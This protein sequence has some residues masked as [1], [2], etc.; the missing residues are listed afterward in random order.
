M[1]AGE[2]ALGTVGSAL[3][4][5]QMRLFAAPLLYLVLQ[6]LLSVPGLTPAQP[7]PLLLSTLWY[8]VLLHS[9]Y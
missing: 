7:G 2:A 9:S 6:V 3:M 4:T 8:R 1:P 5:L